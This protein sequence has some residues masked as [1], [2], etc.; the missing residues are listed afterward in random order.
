VVKLKGKL[1]LV[2][3]MN[4]YMGSRSAAALILKLEARWNY[5][6]NIMHGCFSPGKEQQNPLNMKLGGPQGRFRRF[7]KTERLF[8]LP[9]FE[10]QTLQPVA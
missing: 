7:W 10:P 1:V 8:I 2:Y 6:A 3:T 4:A 5:V 9:A